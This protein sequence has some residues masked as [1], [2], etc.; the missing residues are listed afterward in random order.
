MS[1]SISFK[2]DVSSLQ[3][4]TDWLGLDGQFFLLYNFKIKYFRHL[5]AGAYDHRQNSF[6]SQGITKEFKTLTKQFCFSGNKLHI[7]FKQYFC[8]FTL[9]PGDRSKNNK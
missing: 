7:N 5:N 8:F 6:A 2:V 9:K 1:E 3:Y 4:L